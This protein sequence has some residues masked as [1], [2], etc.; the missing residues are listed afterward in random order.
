[1]STPCRE[2]PRSQTSATV[3]NQFFN[4]LL[5]HEWE[6]RKESWYATAQQ[7]TLLT[8]FDRDHILVSSG[9]CPCK[10]FR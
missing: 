4:G 9:V 2:N 10:P 6:E 7:V 5:S 8:G 1:M 3:V